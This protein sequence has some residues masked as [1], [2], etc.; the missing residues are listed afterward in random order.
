MNKV[1]L[2]IV[3]ALSRGAGKEREEFDEQDYY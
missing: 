3:F 2:L 1:D